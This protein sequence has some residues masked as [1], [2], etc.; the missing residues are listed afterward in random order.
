MI[1]KVKRGEIVLIDLSGAQYN[2][3]CSSR[4]AIV[5]QNDV[6]NYYSPTTIVIPLT[7]KSKKKLPTHVEIKSG[8]ETG[9]KEKSIALCE[10]VRSVDK[11]RIIKK[12]GKINN[13]VLSDVFRA[14]VANFGEI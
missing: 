7:S 1:E 12:L 10:Q 13:D 3:Q 4:P 8:N 2:E 6:G 14:Y 5:I 9:L 11:R